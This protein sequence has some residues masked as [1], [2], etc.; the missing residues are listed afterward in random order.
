[1]KNTGRILQEEREKKKLSLHEIGMSLKIN[2][3]TLQALEEGNLTKLLAKS[4]LRGFVKSYAKYLKLNESEILESFHKEMFAMDEGEK[5][6]STA[7]MATGKSEAHTPKVSVSE[8]I[9]RAASLKKSEPRPPLD[10]N[11]ET[12]FAWH[13]ALQ[14]YLNEPAKHELH[15]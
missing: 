8:Q 2:P 4:F 13:L 15:E 7:T 11:Q 10:T 6:S 12:L 1:M 5:S 9:N 3:K 14:R